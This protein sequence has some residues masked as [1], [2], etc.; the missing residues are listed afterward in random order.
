MI[1][2]CRNNVMMKLSHFNERYDL[3]EQKLWSSHDII[4]M[5]RA[6]TLAKLGAN[7][8]EVP[9]GAVI[10][11]DNQVIGEGFNAPIQDSDATAHAEIVALRSACKALN[12]YRLPTNSTLYVTLEPCTMCIGA[13]IHARV[14]RL[15][16]A[17]FEPR[18][19]MVGSQMDLT[20]QSFYNHQLL[21]N[22]GLFAEQSRIMLQQFFKNRRNQAKLLKKAAQS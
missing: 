22:S 15:V 20:T 17:T 6:L 3:S 12:N 21:V 8:G 10:V 14:A 18:A 1:G 7:L 19:G 9:V 13:L 5:Q 11:H 4:W 16:F 2:S